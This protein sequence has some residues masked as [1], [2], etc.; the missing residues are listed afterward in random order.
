MLRFLEFIFVL[1]SAFR[2]FQL[3]MHLLKR[4]SIFGEYILFMV[5]GETASHSEKDV[6]TPISIEFILNSQAF[7]S[8]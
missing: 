1:I 8:N 6:L 5:Y 3:D 7:H 4:Y 2:F